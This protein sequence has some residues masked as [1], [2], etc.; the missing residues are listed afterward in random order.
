M[1]TLEDL[2]PKHGQNIPVSLSPFKVNQ[3]LCE[4]H[5]SCQLVLADGQTM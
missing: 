3:P 5:G 1:T 2:K 4:L